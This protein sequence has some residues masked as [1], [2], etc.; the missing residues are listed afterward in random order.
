MKGK[1]LFLTMIV[2]IMAM[3]SSTV[4]ATG[5]P[6]IALKGDVSIAA[7]VGSTASVPLLAVE[8]PTSVD[9]DY[10]KAYAA[11]PT[12]ANKAS[13]TGVALVT[14]K[15]AVSETT[16]PTV[17]GTTIGNT[18][19]MAQTRALS[20]GTTA[21]P[22]VGITIAADRTRTLVSIAYFAGAVAPPSSIAIVRSLV[23]P[24]T[25]GAG[26]VIKTMMNSDKTT[27]ARGAASGSASYTPLAFTWSNLC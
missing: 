16:T 21:S 8:A 6:P 3:L 9:V 2:M 5:A 18:F 19:E 14:D 1:V 27:D 26:D 15:A 11:T 23:L 10:T 22:D 4:L 20:D 12:I 25:N 17:C 7:D 13:T 24:P